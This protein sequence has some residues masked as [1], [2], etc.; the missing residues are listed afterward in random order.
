[1]KTT[2]AGRSAADR[3]AFA[4]T[5]RVELGAGAVLDAPHVVA[6]VAVEDEDGQQSADVRSHRGRAD[7]GRSCSGCGSCERTV[8]S[9]PALLHSRASIRV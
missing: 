2:S 4:S 9:W 3:G 5:Q 8:T 7:R 1:M 6:V